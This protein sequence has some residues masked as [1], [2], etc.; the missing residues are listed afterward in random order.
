MENI[1]A[2]DL[3]GAFEEWVSGGVYVCKKTGRYR[4][5]RGEARLKPTPWD[6]TVRARFASAAEFDQAARG[7]AVPEPEPIAVVV[8]AKGR[9]RKANAKPAPA[10]KP[11]RGRV[12]AIALARKARKG[13]RKG[14]RK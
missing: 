4:Y 13:H 6:E 12:D 10:A 11:R 3:G 7:G 9:R 2:S 5:R 1:K 8:P 14:G